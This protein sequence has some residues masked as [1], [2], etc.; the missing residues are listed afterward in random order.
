M[1]AFK[2]LFF[3]HDKTEK[4]FFNNTEKERDEAF[5]VPDTYD[6]SQLSAD[7]DKKYLIKLG[8]LRYIQLFCVSMFCRKMRCCH[9]YQI[10]RMMRLYK[11]GSEK[12]DEELNLLQ[13]LK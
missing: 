10:I 11:L 1:T 12:L 4:V 3:A 2:Y 5:R 13:F 9:K 8:P 7:M 6:N